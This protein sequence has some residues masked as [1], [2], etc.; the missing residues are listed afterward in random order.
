MLLFKGYCVCQADL[1]SRL[2]MFLS[3]SA[4]LS[5]YYSALRQKTEWSDSRIPDFF[6]DSVSFGRHIDQVPAIPANPAHWAD[7]TKKRKWP[8][9]N[10]LEISFPFSSPKCPEGWNYGQPWFQRRSFSEF[11]FGST[12]AKRHCP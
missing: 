3:D 11:T 7:W 1:A 10:F 8:I 12:P 9:V 5:V 4:R 2:T 6:V